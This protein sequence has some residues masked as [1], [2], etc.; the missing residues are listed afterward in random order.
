MATSKYAIIQHI[1]ALLSLDGTRAAAS[2]VAAVAANPSVMDARL[3]V[4]PTLCY[5]VG[6]LAR[7]ED[8]RHG[9]GADHGPAVVVEM[10]RP[11]AGQ[12]S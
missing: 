2:G 5:V 4:E 8:G 7:E 3:G 6:A 11:S 12:A 9:D 10:G 1:P